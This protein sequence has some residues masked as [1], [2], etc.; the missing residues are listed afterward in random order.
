MLVQKERKKLSMRIDVKLVEKMCFRV[1]SRNVAVN[2]ELW[3]EILMKCVFG[4]LF[5][6]V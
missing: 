2:H 1:E 5:G 3:P 6:G 4:Y